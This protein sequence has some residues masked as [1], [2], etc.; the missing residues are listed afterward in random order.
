MPQGKSAHTIISWILIIVGLTALQLV[1][2]FILG[3]GP[4][5]LLGDPWCCRAFPTWEYKSIEV[6]F[7]LGYPLSF[8]PIVPI[9]LVVILKR[10]KMTAWFATP[11]WLIWALSIMGFLMSLAFQIRSYSFVGSSQ[12]AGRNAKL[13]EEV[14]YDRH[15][16]DVPDGVNSTP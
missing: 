8:L 7:C 3:S 1:F 16:G 15:G 13:A 11:T 12:S 10:R 6:V 9:F 5:P 4:R 2:S 14:Y